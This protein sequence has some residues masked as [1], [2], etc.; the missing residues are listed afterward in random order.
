MQLVQIG[1]E[2]KY[3][4]MEAHSEGGEEPERDSEHEREEL[5]GGKMYLC[6]NVDYRNMEMSLA[7]EIREASKDLRNQEK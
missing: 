5:D 3:L 1:S 4:V 7:Q 2:G 6:Y